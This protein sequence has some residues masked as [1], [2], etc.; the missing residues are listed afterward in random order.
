MLDSTEGWPLLI[1]VAVILLGAI[2]LTVV[3]RRVTTRRTSRLLTRFGTVSTDPVRQAARAKTLG[4]VTRSALIGVIWITA[5]LA[6][7]QVLN[8]AFSSFVIAVTLLGSALTF[9]AQSLIRDVLSGFFILLEDQYAV[10]D[11][12][13]LGLASGTVER[14][15]L[16]VTRLR[17][18][19]GEVWWVPNGQIARAGNLTQ[20]WARAVID[21][22]LG[23]RERRRAGD[24]HHRRDRRADRGPSRAWP[25]ACSSHRGRSGSS[26]CRPPAHGPGHGEGGEGRAGRRPPAVQAALL[27]AFKDGRLI[28]PPVI[29]YPGGGASGRRAP[30]PPGR[31]RGRGALTDGACRDQCYG[32]TTTVVPTGAQFQHEHRV[33]VGLAEAA[34][35]Q[36]LAELL[37]G[38]H[39]PAVLRRDLVEA[40]AAAL[41]P[42]READHVVPDDR[43]VVR[44]E[45]C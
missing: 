9:G 8:Q 16:R 10:G 45:R 5:V 35:A 17:D 28:S 29:D 26:R 37:D 4:S 22:A 24:G 20:D 43:G 38:L 21:V 36:G 44:R 14:V 6:M 41:G 1:K 19:S 3:A 40:D 25:T 13:D 42:D 2:I 15:T 11:Q 34:T 39:R 18:A 31:G 7:I 33:V 27:P 30:E 32:T 12:I 23:P